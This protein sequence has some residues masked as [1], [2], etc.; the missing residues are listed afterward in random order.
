[1]Q[2]WPLLGVSV[3]YKAQLLGTSTT[4][5]RYLTFS[6]LNDEQKVEM[7]AK[8]R[9][10]RTLSYR[11]LAYLY[12]GA[13]I[14]VEEI[15][16]SKI[17]FI[18]ATRQG[19]YEQLIKDLEFVA[20]NLQGITEVQNG[21]VNAVVARHM[22]SEVYVAAGE[23]QDAVEAAT[24]VI[25]DPTTELMQDRFGARANETP[26]DVYWDLFRR[27]NQNRSSGNTEVI[28]VMQFE[29][30]VLG[31]GSETNSFFGSFTLEWIY[32][33]LVRDVKINGTPAFRWPIGD[34]TGG[35]GIGWGISTVYFSD[36]IWQS[37]FDNDIRNANHNFVREYVSNNPN[38]PYLGQTISI[39]NPFSGVQVPSRSFY[40][41]QTKATTPFNHP[42]E[43]YANR[44]TYELKSTGG[45]TYIDQYIFRLAETY[46]LRAEVYLRLENTAKTA[47]DINVVRR[48]T[49]ASDALAG[50]VTIDYILDK[51][52][53]E[54]GVE[55]K[56][57]LTLMH[58][59]L[60][61][62]RVVKH[63]SY[64][65]NEMLERYNLWS[66]PAAE[67]ERIFGAEVGQNPGYN[68]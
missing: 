34:Y 56:R 53:R 22:M 40:V 55:E 8:A 39:Q 58:L 64:Y 15:T 46:L 45:G 7:E 24:L 61:Y 5:I 18:K 28:W 23:F 4:V 67:M 60:L 27:D 12:G 26:G 17:D 47:D 44:E 48:R 2:N 13:P 6:D 57:R 31:G 37:D 33:P 52:M 65:K 54:F 30:N 50:D 29:T 21:K 32:S 43:L 1:M 9:F 10:F 19:R 25:D 11:T 35:R 16:E 3:G 38:S 20:D 36:T 66:I 62:D 41:Y 63:N 42:D 59:S 14:T 68:K 51:R 49:H